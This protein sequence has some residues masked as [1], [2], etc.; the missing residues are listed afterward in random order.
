MAPVNALFWVK[1]DL[2]GE[3]HARSAH[4]VTPYAAQW[5]GSRAGSP[6]TSPVPRLPKKVC[7]NTI[8]AGVLGRNRFLGGTDE[9]GPALAGRSVVAA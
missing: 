9:F 1:N 2:T 3:R 4:P 8:F 7:A 5:A 6:L